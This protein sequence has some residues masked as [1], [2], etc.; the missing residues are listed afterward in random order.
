ME[1]KASEF[2]DRGLKGKNTG[3]KDTELHDW[4]CR[5]K[6]CVM[7]LE[8]NDF[9][10]QR[11]IMSE[12]SKNSTIQPGSEFRPLSVL[13]PIFENHPLWHRV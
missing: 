1:A 8:D 3:L 11:I 10:L 4:T 13:N 6:L 5:L 2:L 7:T 9:D 12:S